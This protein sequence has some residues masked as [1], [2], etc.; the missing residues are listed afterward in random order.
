MGYTLPVIKSPHVAHDD[1]FHS[2]VVAT[3]GYPPYETVLSA[4]TPAAAADLA[5]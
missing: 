2:A 5:L 3:A 1:P 4:S